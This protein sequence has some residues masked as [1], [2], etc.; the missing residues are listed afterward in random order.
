MKKR[1]YLVYLD[2]RKKYSP[3]DFK[4]V[5]YT[6]RE[7]LQNCPYLEIRDIR[8][9]SYFIEIDIGTYNTSVAITKGLFSPIISIGSPILMEELEEKKDSLSKEDGVSQSIYLF[10]MERYWKSHEV[11]EGIW[12]DSYGQTKSILNGIIL[13]DAAYVHLQ[14]GEHDIFFSILIRSIE[15]FKDAPDYFFN[16]NVNTLLENID[17]IINNRRTKIFKIMIN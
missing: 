7:L 8:I 9:S 1:R 11:L 10:N 16:I 12:K 2:N 17:E 6:I 5:L 14:K 3:R 4:N 13:I 15:K